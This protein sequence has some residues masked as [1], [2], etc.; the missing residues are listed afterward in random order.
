MGKSVNPSKRWRTHKTVAKYGKEKY[1][2]KHFAIH[3]AINKYG[4]D[5]FIFTVS[6]HYPTNDSLNEAEKYW[7]SYLRSQRIKLYNETDGGD[8]TSPGTKFT[9]THKRN[10]SLAKI[11]K[12]A[13]LDARQSMSKA[14]KLEFAGEKNNKAKINES[15]VIEIRTLYRTGRYTHRTLAKMF[16]LT[17]ATIG[18]II[19]QELWPHVTTN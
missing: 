3:T 9:E 17:H 1:P 18:K 2:N 11:G 5:K 7:I 12:K 14:R 6:E 10:I 19:R 15:S 4:I 8:G 16:D 13:S